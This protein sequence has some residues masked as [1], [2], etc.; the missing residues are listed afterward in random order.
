VVFEGF[1][2]GLQLWN[3]KELEE[4]SARLQK[5]DILA[6]KYYLAL[7]ADYNEIAVEAANYL[8]PLMDKIYLF[9]EPMRLK[10]LALRDKLQ[11]NHAGEIENFQKLKNRFPFNKEILYQFGEVYIRP[12]LISTSIILRR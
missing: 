1:Y 9:P 6:A 4:A 8:N 2:Q 10:I 3:R 7:I 5:A 12:P 11:F